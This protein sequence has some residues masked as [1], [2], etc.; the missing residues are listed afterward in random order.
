MEIGAGK[1]AAL[2]DESRTTAWR[3]LCELEEKDA[4]DGGRRVIRRGPRLTATLE[5]LLSERLVTPSMVGI[6][7]DLA[8]IKRTLEEHESS[9]FTLA[10]D[11]AEFRRISHA[12]LK[13]V[14]PVR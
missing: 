12:W 8:G 2:R 10:R 11:V 1:L 3:R 9:L 7:N 6:L 13:R 14:S 4:A 5:T